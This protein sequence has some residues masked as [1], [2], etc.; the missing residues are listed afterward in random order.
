MKEKIL[1]P[2]YNN[3]IRYDFLLLVLND[4]VDTNQ[5]PIVELNLEAQP[6]S[7]EALT[8]IGFGSQSR[9]SWEP[10]YRLKKVD[11][12]NV[13]YD[14]CVQT[15]NAIASDSLSPP[16]YY[17]LNENFHLCTTGVDRD[18]CYGDTGGPIL[19]RVNGQLEQI[20][21]I[22]T[23]NGCVKTVGV[24]PR[25]SAA[26]SWLFNEICIRASDPKPRLCDSFT[27]SP[28][29]SPMPT[30]TQPTNPPTKTPTRPPT[31]S[32]T[33]TPSRSPSDVPSASPTT[34]PSPTTSPTVCEGD[35]CEDIPPLHFTGDF[36]NCNTADLTGNK[37]IN[38][39][40]WVK[41][42]FCRL[43]CFRAGLGYEGDICCNANEDPGE[44]PTKSPTATPTLPS[45]E[46]EEENCTPCDNMPNPYMLTVGADCET[47]SLVRDKCSKNGTWR[48]EKWCRL[49][50]YKR[51]NGYEGDKCCVFSDS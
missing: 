2:D 42:K 40:N 25:V 3:D 13:N 41:S 34:T 16:R 37:C 26:S 12:P 21:I 51:G 8:M 17:E 38:N 27:D 28:S 5:Y 47:S 10:S 33:K 46:V 36:L 49:S 14:A 23:G 24:Y 20:G 4:D 18:A 48:Q 45:G 50:C 44:Y 32:P 22:S 29:A 9:D 1:H 35:I 15:Y 30:V 7:G 11:M 31:P 43:G 19:K 6:S 39:A